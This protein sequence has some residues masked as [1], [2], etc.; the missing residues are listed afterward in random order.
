MSPASHASIACRKQLPPQ[1][2]L[3]MTMT[4][5]SVWLES[6]PSKETTGPAQTRKAKRYENAQSEMSNGAGAAF[7]WARGL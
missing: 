3:V 5:G 6:T 2:T 1:R 4:I 7:A